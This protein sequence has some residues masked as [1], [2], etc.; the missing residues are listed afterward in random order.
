MAHKDNF[1]VGKWINENKTINEI[2]AIAAG[3]PLEQFKQTIYKE[4]EDSY[5]V[6]EKNQIKAIIEPLRSVLEVEIELEDF[7]SEK[8]NTLGDYFII[9][10]YRTMIFGN[11]PQL[12]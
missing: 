12:R 4:I 5:G 8:D 9:H 11:D 3:S 7:T 2:K 6:E 1:N 10:V